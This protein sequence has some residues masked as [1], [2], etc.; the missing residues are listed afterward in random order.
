[1]FSALIQ[2]AV[3]W[4]WDADQTMWSAH[5]GLHLLFD[6]ITASQLHNLSKHPYSQFFHILSCA[7]FIMWELPTAV[8]NGPFTQPKL[9]AVY[10]TSSHYRSG[11]KTQTRPFLHH[12]AVSWLAVLRQLLTCK[13]WS[14]RQSH[15]IKG[16]AFQAHSFIHSFQ[17]SK[18][19]CQRP[20]RLVISLC[21][22]QPCDFKR[23]QYNHPS[24]LEESSTATRLPL[25]QQHRYTV[26]NKYI[27]S[28]HIIQQL[29]NFSDDNYKTKSSQC[30]LKEIRTTHYNKCKVVSMALHD[31]SSQHD[32]PWCSQKTWF[33][34]GIWS[35]TFLSSEVP[36][37]SL[38][39]EYIC[40]GT[41]M[42]ILELKRL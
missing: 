17:R 7:L 11:T 29:P 5:N 14:V 38:H 30:T 37:P 34:W 32:F 22:L 40:F 13:E 18:E 36:Q 20:N 8:S 25:R 12:C 28:Y 4:L 31:D 2:P 21:T 26:S 10:H 19:S 24:C 6:S 15:Q 33:S 9:R 3:Q 42:E 39:S 27:I 41:Q 1:M 35:V 23:H 16:E